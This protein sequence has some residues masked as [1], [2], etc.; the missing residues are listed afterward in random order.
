MSSAKEKVEAKIK[1]K[2]VMVFSKSYCPYCKKAKDVLKKYNLKAEEYEVWEIENEPDCQA[3]Q[4][5]LKKIT[6][7]SSVSSTHFDVEYI[8]QIFCISLFL[9]LICIRIDLCIF[10]CSLVCG[11]SVIPKIKFLCLV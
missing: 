3:I 4:A 6:G 11:Q 2:K 5:E 9:T 7:A 8:L 1:G 10:Y